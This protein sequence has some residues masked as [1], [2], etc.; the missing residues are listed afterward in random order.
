M[1]LFQ[2]DGS[3]NGQFVKNDKKYIFN[4][5]QSKKLTTLTKHIDGEHK[6]CV[7]ISDGVYD[8]MN[9]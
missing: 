1:E 9:E 7:S 3:M 5:T 8:A 2:P 4:T 6:I